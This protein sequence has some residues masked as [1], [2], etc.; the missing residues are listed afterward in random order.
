MPSVLIIISSSQLDVRYVINRYTFRFSITEIYPERSLIRISNKSIRLQVNTSLIPGFSGKVN[1][2]ARFIGDIINTTFFVKSYNIVEELDF[3][4]YETALLRRRKFLEN[5]CLTEVSEN[6]VH[7]VLCSWLQLISFKI[8]FN[9]I[10]YYRRVDFYQV[11]MYLSIC[12]SKE[13]LERLNLL[14]NISY[15]SYCNIRQESSDTLP[16]TWKLCETFYLF[17]WRLLH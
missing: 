12:F 6:V 10:F 14:K 4:L 9:E 13:T 15:F 7:L 2:K 3:K 5:E 17:I 11:M 16:K 8:L 1:Q